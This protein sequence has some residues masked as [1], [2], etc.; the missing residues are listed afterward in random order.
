MNHRELEELLKQNT[1]PERDEAYW[2]DF[3]PAVSR[4]IRSEERPAAVPVRR[5]VAAFRMWRG[6]AAAAGA[7]AL[8]A[9]LVAP[10]LR[11]E[12]PS[13]EQLQA[14]RTC[15]RQVSELFP[16]QLEAVVLGPDGLQLQLSDRPNVPISPVLYV[17][18]CTPASWCTTALT[19]SGQVI[20]AGGREFEILAD[21]TG[22]IFLVAED[23]VWTPGHAPPSGEPWRLE[24]GWLGQSL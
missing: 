16:R 7:A 1:P 12:S 19:F 14:L 18:I 9:I 8:V 17:R 13:D 11:R 3:P 22:H 24:S 6:L 15:Y 23:G 5:G 2:R 10:R 20:R 4:R 21:G